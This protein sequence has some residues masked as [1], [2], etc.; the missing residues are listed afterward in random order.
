MKVILLRDVKKQGKNDEIIE[1]SDGFAINYLIKRGLAVP[2]T[3]SSIAKLNKEL[4]KKYDKEQEV[5]DQCEKVRK[6]LENKEIIF[7][8][9]TGKEDK[10]FGS[11]SSKQI[12]EELKKQGFEIEKKHI[13]IDESLDTIGTHN[14]KIELH[15]KVKFDIRVVLRK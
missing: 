6:K 3:K 5:I 4:E 14:V 9:K 10:V 12:S 1:V 11:I 8:V 15:K 13:N 2:E 7:N